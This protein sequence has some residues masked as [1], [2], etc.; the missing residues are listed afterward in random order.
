MCSVALN[1]DVSFCL[2]ISNITQIE[3]VM[4]GLRWNFMEGSTVVQ[5]TS[6]YCGGNLDHHAI[7][8]QIMSRFGKKI[9]DSPARSGLNEPRVS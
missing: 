5:E 7:N 8:Q 1:S 3:K 6:D 9:Q 2:S 4:K